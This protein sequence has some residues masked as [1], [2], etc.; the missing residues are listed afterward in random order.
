MANGHAIAHR[1]AV[2]A[3]EKTQRTASP[4][5]KVVCRPATCVCAGTHQPFA[6]EKL[7]ER[8]AKAVP[9]TTSSSPTPKTDCSAR[10]ICENDKTRASTRR[11]RPNRGGMP[12][13]RTA[14]VGTA[15]ASCA[16][17]SRDVPL[18]RTRPARSSGAR[19]A[20]TSTRYEEPPEDS[21]FARDQVWSRTVL[22]RGSRRDVC[23]DVGERIEPRRARLLLPA[24]Q[25]S[26]IQD[27]TRTAR[28][29][30]TNATSQEG[31]ETAARSAEKVPTVERTCGDR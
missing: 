2:C 1:P 18:L 23:N 13:A 25:T 29:P 19:N 16:V 9:S 10:R 14:L 15:R 28:R 26:S 27:Q 17:D 20:R 12:C 6:P 22:E 31:R 30:G 24:T 21:T 11:L 4:I 3:D 7:L 8:F 5:S